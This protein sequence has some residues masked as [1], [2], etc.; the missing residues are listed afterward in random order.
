MI[1]K[2]V[3]ITDLH[4]KTIQQHEN[5]SKYFD[6][7]IDEISE[8]L[9]EYNHSEIRIVITGDIAHHK[10]NI[11]NEQI[12]LT[13]ELLINLSKI[14]K[15]V[16][17]PGN[18]DFLENNLERIDSITPIIELMKNTNIIYH[19]D[20]GVFTDENIKWVVYSLYQHNVKPNYEK[21]KDF[22]YV[23]LFHGPINGFSTDIG[24]VFEDVFDK[25]NF[26]GC[27]IVLCGDIHKR[28]TQ[29]LNSFDSNS[30]RYKD[31]SIIYQGSFI[32][33]NFGETIKHHGYGLY[34]V[35]TNKYE[36][37]DLKNEQPYMFFKIKDLN[38]LGT[39]ELLN[40]G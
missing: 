20:T 12:L 16:I 32:Q 29:Y 26:H 25:V 3:H 23:G 37:F 33:Q 4:I 14:G 21:E 27:D 17:I 8:K 6:V 39:E 28:A 9:D 35:L 34:D 10:I 13:S 19:K 40:N 36:S 1:K 11:S 31:I 22:L 30:N 2:I 5:Y 24:Y 38:E 15:V 18:H 7:F